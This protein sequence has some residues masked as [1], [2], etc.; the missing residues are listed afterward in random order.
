[1]PDKDIENLLWW[2]AVGTRGGPTKLRLLRALRECPSNTNQLALTLGVDYKTAQ[3]HL[4][5]LARNG[6]VTSLGEGYGRVFFLSERV[7]ENYAWFER[8][9]QRQA[10]LGRARRAADVA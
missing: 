4:R 6:V 5:L 3:H 7:A 9:Y 8:A 2:L 1:M 10:H